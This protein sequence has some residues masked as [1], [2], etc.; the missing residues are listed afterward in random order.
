MASGTAHQHIRLAELLAALSHALDM[1]EGQPVGHCVRACWIGLNV[2][3]KMGLTQGQLSDLYYTILLKDLGC[4]SNAARICAHYITCDLTFKNEFKKVDGSLPQV[5]NFVIT[6]SGVKANM[7]D[8]FR[9]IVKTLRH[10]GQISKELIETRCQ[11]GAEI[12]RQMH[13]N[14]AVQQGIMSL[15]EHWDGTGQPD[16]LQGLEIPL[17]SQIALLGQVAD[18]FFMNDGRE[19]AITAVGSRAGTWFNPKVVEAFLTLEKDEH[20]WTMLSRADLSK[21]IYEFEPGQSARIADED[22]LD[23]I[24]QAFAQVVDS[25]SPFTAGHSERV[26]LFADLIAEQMGYAEERR[27]W[28]RRAALLHD[29]G[30]LGVSNSVLDK[31]GR[32]D[33]NE[34]A[35]IKKHPVFSKEILDNICAFGDIAPVAGG[36]HE[37]LD[38]KG[39]PYG[40]KGDEIDMDTRIVTVADIF[41]ALTADR[42]YR[43]A[44]PVEK[45]LGIMREMVDEAIDRNCFTALC[46]AIAKFDQ[47]PTLDNHAGELKVA[48]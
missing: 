39:Y 7:A 38:G 44:M 36:H 32:L 13:F 23:D 16:R 27:R 21:H 42:P 22:Y 19:Q 17:Y 46:A 29:I 24:A 41:D 3:K 9:S 47:L 1:T 20:F 15:D 40:L 33:D 35:E 10:G 26:T 4:S 14:D 8:K 12:A 30:K 6:Q 48:V 31:P 2:G 28:L 25:K 37:R 34:F 45:A 11:R 18:V 43:A 5:L